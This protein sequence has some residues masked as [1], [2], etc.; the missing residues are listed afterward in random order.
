[1]KRE[2]SRSN[3]STKSLPDHAARPETQRSRFFSTF[4]IAGV[5]SLKSAPYSARHRQVE[6]FRYCP[7]G[8]IG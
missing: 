6:A 3:H 5:Y 1:M 8:E 2:I 7:D 4:F